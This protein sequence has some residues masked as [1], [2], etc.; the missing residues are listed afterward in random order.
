MEGLLATMDAV[1]VY[2][3]GSVGFGLDSAGRMLA[4]HLPAQLCGEQWKQVLLLGN[5]WQEQLAFE[6]ENSPI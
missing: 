6:C 5:C 4:L 3:L 2:R 1:G